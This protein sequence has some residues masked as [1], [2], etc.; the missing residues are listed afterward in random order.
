MTSGD[1]R[2][3]EIKRNDKIERLI[4]DTVIRRAR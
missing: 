4:I 3:I 2:Y 1:Q